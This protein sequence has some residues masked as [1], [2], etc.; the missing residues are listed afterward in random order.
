[1]PDETICRIDR[2]TESIEREP[3]Q[4][5]HDFP[6]TSRAMDLELLAEKARNTGAQQITVQK[7]VGEEKKGAVAEP[8]KKVGEGKKGA[9][10]EPNSFGAQQVTMITPGKDTIME[11]QSITRLT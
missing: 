6:M 11:E 7:K 8:N 2:D 3:V 4:S 10:A 5:Q 9:M 1:M